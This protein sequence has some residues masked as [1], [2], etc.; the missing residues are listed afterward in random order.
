M[1]ACSGGADSLALAAGVAEAVRQQPR[2]A[3]VLVVDHGLQPGSAE[4]A[5]DAVGRCRGL[6][7]PGTVVRVRVE[8]PGGPEASARDARHR[9]LLAE[10]GVDDAVVLLG[11]TLD[12][13][14]EQVLLGLAR[15]SGPRSLAGMAVRRG[16]LLR[17][18]LGLRRADTEACCREL[19]LQPWQDPTNADPAL[20]RARVRHRVLP[21]LEAELGPGLAEALART[22]DLC[23]RDAEALD[24]LAGRH[25]TEAEPLCADLLPLPPAVRHRVLRRWLL[26]RGARQPGHDHV[27][28]V[29]ALLTSW[30]GQGPIDVP[31]VRVRRRDGRLTTS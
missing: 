31:G 16:P 23:R 1:V 14:A 30:R 7:L 13:Q 28:A 17:P 25:R 11:H 9:A 24:E 6:G 22:A 26:E 12:D 29:D 5:A 8:G 19:G 4:A 18:L 3:R 10:A 15:G 2:P 21:L 27:L 20:T